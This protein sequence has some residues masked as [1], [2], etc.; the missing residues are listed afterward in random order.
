[1]DLKARKI[2]WEPLPNVLDVTEL[3]TQSPAK[4]PSKRSSLKVNEGSPEKVTVL[5]Q[6]LVFMTPLFQGPDVEMR[7]PRKQQDKTPNPTHS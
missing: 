5:N 7:R 3:N 1:M 6:I 4:M 2:T